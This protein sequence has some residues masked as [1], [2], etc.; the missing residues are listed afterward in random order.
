[1]EDGMSTVV[2]TAQAEAWNS[3]EGVHWAEHHDRWNVVNGALDDPLFKAAAIGDGDRVLDIGCGTGATT[4]MAARRA[5]RG[6]AV[7]LDL[8]EPMLRRARVEATAEAIPNVTF[9]QGDAQ[10]YPFP[11]GAFDVAI[12]RFSVMYFGDPVAAFANIAQGLRPDG[13]RLVFVCP[14]RLDASAAFSVPVT[15]LVGQAPALLAETTEPGMFSLGDRAHVVDLLTRAG[16]A[17]VTARSIEV[18]LTYGRDATDAAKFFLGTVPVRFMLDHTDHAAVER[19]HQR[20]IA[21][22]IPY[23]TA[24]GVRLPGEHWL[25]TARR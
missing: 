6:H 20:L 22:F 19:A 15:A 23:Q 11:G 7:G 18:P 17:D 2:N 13:G 9:E 21:A 3:A 10:V 4:R 14:Q 8:S 5:A 1:M 16:F 12:S 25:V 24:D